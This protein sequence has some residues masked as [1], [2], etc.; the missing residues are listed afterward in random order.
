MLSG[1]Q[2]VQAFVTK[3]IHI[4][5]T[6]PASKALSQLPAAG[7]G[8]KL[9]REGTI[10]DINALYKKVTT[11]N[12]NQAWSHSQDQNDINDVMDIDNR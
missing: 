8:R 4:S 10:A 6:L 1:N 11:A 3:V 9:K 5:F 7:G 12:P 2:P